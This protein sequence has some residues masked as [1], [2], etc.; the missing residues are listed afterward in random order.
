MLEHERSVD[1]KH[2]TAQELLSKCGQ[3]IFDHAAFAVIQDLRPLGFAENKDGMAA[4]A[5]AVFKAGQRVPVGVQVRQKSYLPS[6]TAVKT[7]LQKLVDTLR[8]QF[9]E[10][11]TSELTNVGGAVSLD[12]LTLNLQGRH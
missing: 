8:R 10:Q 5:E 11:V 12:G 6:R 3:E 9:A 2:T 4:Y 7:S 1:E